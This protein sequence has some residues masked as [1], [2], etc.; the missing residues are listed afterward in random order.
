MCA[1]PPTVL[2][3]FFT[4]HVLLSYSKM[5]IWIKFSDYFCPAVNCVPFCLCMF[6][7]I[8]LFNVAE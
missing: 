2:V 8:I 5:C 3:Q 1:T 4:L 7:N 6:D